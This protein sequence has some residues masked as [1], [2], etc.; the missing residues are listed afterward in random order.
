MLEAAGRLSTRVPLSADACCTTTDNRV[1]VRPNRNL[2]MSFLSPLLL[3]GAAAVGLPIVLHFL[4]KAWYK[5]LPWAAMDFLRKSLEQTTRRIKFRELIL[6]LLR[7]LAL[8]LLAIALARPLIGWSAFAGRSESVDAVLVIDTSLSMGARDGNATRFER[9]ILAAQSV[10]DNLPSNSTVQIVTCSDRAKTLNMN[11]SNFDQAR[12]LLSNLKVTSQGSN[13]GVGLIEAELALQRVTGSNKEIYLL[14]DFQQNTFEGQAVAKARE[15]KDLA[16]VI[17]VRCS[18]E[19]EEQ[20]LRN[21]VV[22]D[23]R[24]PDAIPPH[25]GT[26]LPFTVILK[27]TGMKPLFNLAVSLT[28]DGFNQ[29]GEQSIDTGL[30]TEIQP[31]ASYPV[32]ITAALNRPG[33][34]LLTA[35]VGTANTDNG[36][37]TLG[38]NSPDDLPGDNRF[39]K[40]ILV[41]ETV[42]VLVV[43]GAP[44]ER[45]ARDSSSHF[46]QNALVPVAETQ[47]QE[48]FLRTKT[49]TVPELQNELLSEYQVCVLTNVP[50]RDEDK[51]GIPALS[52]KS[53]TALKQFVESGGG[54]ILC[55]GEFVNP[56]SYNNVFGGNGA[57]LL[58][59]VL[60]EP[61]QAPQNVPFHPSPDSVTKTDFLTRVREEPFRSIMSA[62][63]VYKAL[64]GRIDGNGSRT[65]LQLDNDQPLISA[66]KVG[67]GEVV[68]F[69]TSADTTWTDWP[70]RASSYVGT[71]L[72]TL[73]HLTSKT[74]RDGNRVAGDRLSWYAP[75]DQVEYEVL[76]PDGTRDLLGK[77]TGGTESALELGTND[78]SLAGEYRIVR[79]GELNDDA[80]RF[81]VI[82]DLRETATLARLTDTDLAM[83]LGY[84]PV[85]ATAGAETESIG[86]LRNQ[87]EWTVPLLFILFGIV[88][89]EAYWAWYCG[90]A[91]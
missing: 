45:D 51:P 36:T 18:Q 38:A 20:K 88:L 44:N 10:I 8:L 59:V 27:N 81:A 13:L 47:Q 65:L 40:L 60:Q 64:P 21:V 19:A 80:P 43:D 28:V 2:G 33:L 17:Y 37:T 56:D 78:T 71:I 11:P 6:L 77:P 73:T 75:Q 72:F 79:L 57:N 29:D 76:K 32:T 15:L 4:F 5:P 52:D 26:R 39:D 67:Q 23:I 30:A 58:P 14:S 83:K 16:Q 63:E 7:C 55:A 34:R 54:L 35:K 74:D 53:L 70:A 31:G 84:E 90:R 42:K 41:R 48:Y 12:N 24:F 22:Q 69:H 87:R 85:L 9:A 91:L 1:S 61:V 62:V 68:L 86:L 3:A 46:F 25:A 82:P 50:A 66:R 89:L 49:I